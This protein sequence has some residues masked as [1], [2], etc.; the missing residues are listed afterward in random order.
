MAADPLL[1]P[2]EKKPQQYVQNIFSSSTLLETNTPTIFPH[3][4][5]N[6]DSS[7]RSFFATKTSA[8]ISNFLGGILFL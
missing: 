8:S 5:I 6:F 7:S 2:I 1:F 4:Q 3:A